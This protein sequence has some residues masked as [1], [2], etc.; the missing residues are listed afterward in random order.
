MTLVLDESIALFTQTLH[1]QHTYTMTKQLNTA[2]TVVLLCYGSSVGTS[3]VPP[4][5]VT[6]GGE[7]MTLVG[8]HGT[9]FLTRRIYALIPPPAG[10]QDCVITIPTGAGYYNIFG[11]L[12]SYTGAAIESISTSSNGI[13]VYDPMVSFGAHPNSLLHVFAQFY[14]FVNRFDSANGV[15]LGRWQSNQLG[16][17]YELAGGSGNIDW[18]F[19]GSSPQSL[20]VVVEIIP[21]AVIPARNKWPFRAAQ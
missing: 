15:E 19:M 2:P 5:S 16:A 17:A 4:V 9:G 12:T 13:G 7:D 8:T 11:A 1:L 20:S 6:Y 21:I 3:E 18:D 14:D 10:I